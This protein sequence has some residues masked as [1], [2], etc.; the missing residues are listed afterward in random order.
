MQPLS[1]AILHRSGQPLRVARLRRKSAGDISP[2]YLQMALAC[3]RP[4][5][6]IGARICYGSNAPF[7]HVEAAI[8]A[9]IPAQIRA[10]S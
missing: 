10:V 9:D 5:P 2:I 1:D 3:S 7:R 4:F 8:C 6:G